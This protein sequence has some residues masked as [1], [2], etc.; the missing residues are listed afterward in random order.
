M[1]AMRERNA[2]VVRSGHD[3]RNARHNFKRNFFGDERFGFFAAATKNKWITAFQAHDN[4]ALAR[5]GEHEFGELFLR[6]T[7]VAFVVATRD[8]LSGRRREPE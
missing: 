5:A 6:K 4:F 3:G 2:R 1:F 7:A 8:N